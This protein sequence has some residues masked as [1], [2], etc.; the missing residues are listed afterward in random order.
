[1]NCYYHFI[2]IITSFLFKHSKCLATVDAKEETR[3]SANAAQDAHV[4]KTANAHQITNV[5]QNV[6]AIM[7]AKVNANAAQ[8]AHAVKTAN[9]HQIISVAQNALAIMELAKN[10]NAAQDAHV[11]KIVTA[12][13][14]ITAAQAAHVAIR[15]KFFFYKTSFII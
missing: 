7:E 4:V 6:H 1:M 11:V 12:L 8:D 9:A 5:A 14:I 3:E 13:K 15:N 10:A 2:I